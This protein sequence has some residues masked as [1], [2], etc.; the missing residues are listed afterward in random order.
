VVESLRGEV[1]I[2]V[3]VN[4]VQWLLY[5]IGNIRQAHFLSQRA[6]GTNRRNSTFLRRPDSARWLVKSRFRSFSLFLSPAWLTKSGDGTQNPGGWVNERDEHVA[7][8]TL[9]LHY[10][11]QKRRKVSKGRKHEWQLHPL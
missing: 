11:R 6:G 10:R 3:M 7:P 1:A 4:L 2:V 8:T 5:Q 9:V